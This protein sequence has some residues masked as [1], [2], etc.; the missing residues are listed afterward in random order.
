M[1]MLPPNFSALPVKIERTAL[2][3][4]AIEFISMLLGKFDWE[5][6]HNVVLKLRPE[7][8]PNTWAPAGKDERIGVQWP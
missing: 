2:P 6:T 3:Y 4:G 5:A 7:K 1:A 8:T